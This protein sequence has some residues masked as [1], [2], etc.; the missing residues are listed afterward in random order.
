V[1]GW[2]KIIAHS[3][4][5]SEQTNTSHQ[6]P[7]KRTGQISGT[8]SVGPEALKVG[9]PRS[10]R[11]H[12]HLLGARQVR[13]GAVREPH[14]GGGALRLRAVRHWCASASGTSSPGWRRWWPCTTSK[15]L[16]PLG[17]SSPRSPAATAASPI[18]R[19]PLPYPSRGLLIDIEPIQK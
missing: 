5:L 16:Q 19:F 17:G 4:F 9:V 13:P 6:P 3:S 8:F 18:S 10:C 11:G 7:A 1:A 12:G 15:A 14:G 2:K